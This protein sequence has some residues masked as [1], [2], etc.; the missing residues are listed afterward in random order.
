VAIFSFLQK[1]LQEGGFTAYL[2]FAAGLI[3]I[4]VSA[5][6]LYYLFFKIRPA[7]KDAISALSKKVLAR[8]YNEALQMCN[9]ANNVPEFEVMKVGLLAVEGG[10]EAMRA[11]LGGTIVEIQR[12]CE[13]RVPIIALIASV[14]T[15][16]GLLGTISGMIRTFSALALATDPSKK[17]EMLGSGISEAMTS[18]A[19]GLIVGIAAMVIHTICTVKTEEVTG[20]TQ[21]TGFHFVTLI[22]KSERGE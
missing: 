4:F 2:T 22:E 18:T 17:A 8:D 6:R 16:L 7:G 21:A 10:R 15:L 13:R 9:S 20:K 5:D 19:G 12:N 14:A 3:L 1:F 11:A